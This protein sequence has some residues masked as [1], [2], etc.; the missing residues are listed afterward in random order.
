M[1]VGVVVLMNEGSRR[2]MLAVKKVM[3]R[4]RDG[5]IRLFLE[6]SRLNSMEPSMVELMKQAKIRPSGRSLLA[7]ELC[8]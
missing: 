1:N 4:R 7:G 2:V 6:T 3:V 5:V 8:A